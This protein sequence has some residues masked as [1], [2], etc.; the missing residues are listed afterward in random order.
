MTDWCYKELPTLFDGNSNDDLYMNTV[1]NTKKLIYEWLTGDAGWE[2][3]SETSDTVVEQLKLDNTSFHVVRA[4]K[5]LKNID[6]NKL[7]RATNCNS[8]E[9]K[10]ELYEDLIQFKVV[11]QL[12]D[13]TNIC[14]SQYKTPFGTM[15]R[16]F[17]SLRNFV[18]LDQYSYLLVNQAV[19]Y[20]PIKF[21]KN[22]VRG[23]NTSGR[24]IKV[25]PLNPTTVDVI[26]VDYVDPKGSVPAFIIN[27]FKTRTGDRLKKMEQ[28]YCV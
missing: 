5:Q 15:N 25:D 10:N 4:H 1:I 27:K 11:K 8:F 6:V 21:N 9:E 17:V 23:V 20:E 24:L 7:I 22:F 14:Y 3:I 16:D 13:S 28:L 26:T 18:K 19:N 2:I 12:D